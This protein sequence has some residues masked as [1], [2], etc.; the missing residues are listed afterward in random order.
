[1][2]QSILAILVLAS[3]SSLSHC[4]KTED[5]T[6]EMFL[7]ALLQTPESPCSV[8]NLTEG[9]QRVGRSFHLTGC[10]EGAITGFGFERISNN[11]L[12]G[13]FHSNSGLGWGESSPVSNVPHAKREVAIEISFQLH[14]QTSYILVGGNVE[15]GSG[16]N[17]LL[18]NAK[19]VH[20]RLEAGGILSFI[21]AQQSALNTGFVSLP[22]QTVTYCL[23]YHREPDGTHMEAH[24]LAWKK[25]CS[26]L[27]TQDRANKDWDAKAEVGDVNSTDLVELAKGHGVGFLAH[28]ATVSRLAIYDKPRA[29][30]GNMLY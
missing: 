17:L 2:K 11:S 3:L 29:T 7:L 4:K 18:N 12:T 15:K 25:P 5:Q 16:T 14:D 8:Q 28:Q 1:M 13:L 6:N 20:I 30:S 21:G 26:Q 22:G 27:T 10:N 24:L 9:G 19:R 23:E